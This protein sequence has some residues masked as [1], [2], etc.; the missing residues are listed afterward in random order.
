VDVLPAHEIDAHQQRQRGG[1]Q[2]GLDK[3]PVMGRDSRQHDD[4]AKDGRGR[5]KRV[6]AAF[7]LCGGQDQRAGGLERPGQPSGS[8]QEQARR[9]QAIGGMILRRSMQHHRWHPDQGCQCHQAEPGGEQ[10]D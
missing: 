6:R 8:D 10:P 2:E 5:G 9:P 3:Q 1:Q 4:E 7:P